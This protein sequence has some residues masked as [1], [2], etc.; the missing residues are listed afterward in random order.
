MLTS[1]N[2][3]MKAI[4]I[5]RSG[6]PEVLEYEEVPRPIAGPGEVLL[7]VCAAG[8]NPADWRGR[9]GFPDLPEHLR[10]TL[11]RPSTPGFDASGI[12]EAVGPGVTEFQEGDAVYG[13]IRF[14]SRSST[15]AEYTTAPVTDLAFKPATIDHLQ[16]A[17]VPM[18]ALTA[19]QFLYQ[20]LEPG[21][22]VLI[23]GAAGGVGHFAVQLAKIKG[24]HVIAVASSRHEVFLRE[25]GVGEY[26]DYTATPVEQAARNVDLVYDTVGGANG[27]RLLSVLKRGGRLVGINIG[28]YSAERAAWLGIT[29]GTK[30]PSLHPDTAQLAEIGHLIDTGQVRVAID[31]V[32]PLSEAYKAHVR[33]EA[34]HMRGKIVLHVGE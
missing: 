8:V 32:V 2:T 5:H 20:D 31:A 25:L 33:G 26:I 1:I 23:N 34:G 18:A 28:N 9:A 21:Q 4:R 29:I 24:A 16:A 22:T 19:W 7:R 12:V 10:P 6:G 11:P 14:L 17:A 13:M 15:Y 27:D 3:T 30:H